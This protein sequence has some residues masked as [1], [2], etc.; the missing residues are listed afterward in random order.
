MEPHDN[1]SECSIPIEPTDEAGCTTIAWSFIVVISVVAIGNF[2]FQVDWIAPTVWLTLLAF[3]LTLNCLTR[4]VNNYAMGQLAPYS[5]DHSL[6]IDLDEDG[7]KVVRRGFALFG[8]R[9]TL[10][11]NTIPLERME[12]IE[13]APEPYNPKSWCVIICHDHDDP[14]LSELYRAARKPN[15]KCCPVLRFSEEGVAQQ[16][17]S[18]LVA[19]LERAGGRYVLDKDGRTYTR[20]G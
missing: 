1:S 4:G 9:F 15:E 8:R 10:D 6:V 2:A 11:T 16:F 19:F 7:S 14:K 5:S 13:L 17:C 12:S 3:W 20:K 18:E